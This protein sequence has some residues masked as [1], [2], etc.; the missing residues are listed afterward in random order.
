MVRLS[1]FTLKTATL[2][3]RTYMSLNTLPQS[4][5]VPSGVGSAPAAPR[6]AT[7]A[8]WKEWVHY[9]IVFTL[10]FFLSFTIM[11]AYAKRISFWWRSE[12]LNQSQPAPTPTIEPTQVPASVPVPVPATEPHYD[13]TQPAQLTIAKIGLKDV[14]VWWNVP[15]DSVIDKLHDGV[16][17]Y[18]GTGTPGSREHQNVFITGHSS[19][20][21]WEGGRYNTVFA[22]LDK[23]VGGDEISIAIGSDTY[24]Y[25]VR[26]AY[27]INPDQTEVLK[28]SPTPILTLM[29]CWPVGTNA[30][31]WIVVADQ[32]SPKVSEAP[33][34]SQ[35]AT[36]PPLQSVLDILRTLVH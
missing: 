15:A 35:H 36:P 19:N 18:L 21:W 29:T 6:P 7:P 33:A 11:P 3:L 26:E 34:A 13:L 31:R 25:K 27:S 23:L 22:L 8:P 17:H 16:A 14:P 30:R 12:Y 20:W 2:I 4:Q 24:V 5:P 9:G 1:F 28:A 10:L 32:I